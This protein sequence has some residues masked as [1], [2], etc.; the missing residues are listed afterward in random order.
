MSQEE[1][2]RII[3]YVN[4]I[5]IE[6]IK[7]EKPSNE[8]LKKVFSFVQE[9]SDKN[10]FVQII[11]E[12]A[13]CTEKQVK[14]AAALALKA[15][16][17]GLAIAKTPAI[18]FLLYLSATRQIR[19]AIEL[20]GARFG[21]NACIVLASSSN[22]ELKHLKEN[23]LER[24]GSLQKLLNK[25]IPNPEYIK[26]LYRISTYRDLKDIELTAL[27]KMALTILK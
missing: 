4:N 16:I 23:L 13:Y 10:R 3:S 15:H 18:E 27:T 19:N 26:E 11:R 25:C 7:L 24:L 12:T 6:L 22:E 17:E 9:F 2:N 20:V 8:L 5:K 21:E 1:I 14:L